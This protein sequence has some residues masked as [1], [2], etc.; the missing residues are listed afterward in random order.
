MHN[1]S[2]RVLEQ[3][4]NAGS[5]RRRVSETV[6]PSLHINALLYT[7]ARNCIQSKQATLAG[8]H[9]HS[10]MRQRHRCT[11]MTQLQGAN[12][13]KMIRTLDG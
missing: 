8:F 9:T 7:L 3:S 12:G 1:G 13:T 6:T 2:R 11:T 5:I 4:N 10:N